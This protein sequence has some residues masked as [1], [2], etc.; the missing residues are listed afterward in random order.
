LEATRDRVVEGPIV[1]DE[2]ILDGTSTAAA[3]S[4]E[5]Y[6]VVD[7]VPQSSE[8][9]FE[10]DVGISCCEIGWSDLVNVRLMF[11]RPGNGFDTIALER[12]R[13]IIER[14]GVASDKVVHFEEGVLREHRC[15]P[16]RLSSE[17]SLGF[18]VQFG[19][20]PI[21]FPGEV[22]FFLDFYNVC[23]FVLSSEVNSNLLDMIPGAAVE[24]LVDRR[25]SFFLE[26]CQ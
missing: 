2:D 5:L 19:R 17:S 4:G 12:A 1:V 20:F 24:V 25:C 6:D 26:S 22:D 16:N 9:V 14:W 11:L 3:K 10:D 13:T 23:Q 8:M 21:F 18:L 15:W 7:R